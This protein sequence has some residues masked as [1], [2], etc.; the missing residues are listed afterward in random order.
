MKIDILAFGSH[1]DDVEL[2]CG[3]TLTKQKH[4]G[5]TVGIIDLTRS[6]LSS[7]GTVAIRQQ[8]TEEA[9][10]ILGIDIR[11][12]LGFADGFFKNDKEH[13][14]E[15]I[16]MIRKYQPTVVIT[17]ALSDRHPDHGRGQQL[18][19]DACFLAGLSMIET[20]M[21]G[22]KQKEWRPR[23][24]YNYIQAY[25]IEPQFV[26][27]ITGFEEIKMQSILAYK[28]Q[29]YNPNSNEKD[30]FISSKE[31]LDFV[32][33]RMIQHGQIAG[34]KFAEGYTISRYIA[35]DNIMNLY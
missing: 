19:S 17:N 34:Y 33:T 14:L 30:T 21:N 3:G 5:N 18:V 24:V 29:F 32:K 1:P 20:T 25:N 11:E 9:S 26:I 35:T 7:R 4:L 15:V 10:K 8:E 6:E 23:N 27:D 12:N 28:S 31:F 2:G 22:E 13:Q 16:K